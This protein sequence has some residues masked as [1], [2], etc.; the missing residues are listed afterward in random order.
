MSNDSKTGVRRRDV[1][2]W[3]R[4]NQEHYET[5]TALAEAAFDVFR[6]PD[7]VLEDQT[8]WLFDEALEAKYDR[9]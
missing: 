5:A 4:R 7:D 1:R 6:L 2:A 9:P 8:H 3:M